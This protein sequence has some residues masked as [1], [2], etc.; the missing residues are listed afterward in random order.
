MGS[1]RGASH[2]WISAI[3]MNIKTTGILIAIFGTWA[4]PAIAQIEVQTVPLT[5]AS[6]PVNYAPFDPA[7]GTLKSVDVSVNGLYL[8]ECSTNN[9]ATVAALGVP[10]PYP[11]YF[12]VVTQFDAQAPKLF[13]GFSTTVLNPF[14]TAGTLWGDG[15]GDNA[16]TDV[17]VS[18]SFDFSAASDLA[19]FAV[20]SQGNFQNA[21]LSDFLASPFGPPIET[22]TS[23]AQLIGDPY[24]SVLQLGLEGDVMIQYA[25]RPAPVSTVPDEMGIIASCLAI[26][27]PVALARARDRPAG[28]SLGPRRW[29]GVAFQYPA[30]AAPAA[31]TLPVVVA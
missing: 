27:L 8:L 13:G 1:R 6:G 3:P 30:N 15:L 21:T 29:Q 31:P 11:I 9:Y 10:T 7:L 20:D 2:I 25:Y 16:Y 5:G 4:A 22:V 17:S 24:D 12:D 14:S 26:L 19:G 18:Y 23:T 28:S